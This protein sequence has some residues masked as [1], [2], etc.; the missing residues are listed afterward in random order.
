MFF[1]EF[2]TELYQYSDTILSYLE[3]TDLCIVIGTALKTGMA[4]N[5]VT[6]F[7]TKSLPVVEINIAC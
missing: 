1:D 5:I 2:Y 6:S 3:D 4:R 7:I